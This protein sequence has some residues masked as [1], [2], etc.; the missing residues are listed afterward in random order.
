MLGGLVVVLVLASDPFGDAGP[1]FTDKRASVNVPEP[2]DFFRILA[3][4]LVTQFPFAL[5]PSDDRRDYELLSKPP[6]ENGKHLPQFYFWVRLAGGKSPDH[7]GVLVVWAIDK[8]F[9][10]NGFYCERVL[11]A[12]KGA[13]LRR[14]PA[15][16]RA[17]IQEKLGKKRKST[18]G[19]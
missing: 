9:S 14:F 1:D 5:R 15:D 10:N 7:R 4:D 16:V 3:H 8:H 17:R 6:P 2:S 18:T 13:L 11:R 12:D 19:K